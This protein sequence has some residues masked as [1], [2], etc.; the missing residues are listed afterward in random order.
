MCVA[1]PDRKW[2]GGRRSQPR[3]LENLENAPIFGER[4]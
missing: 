3:F 2:L 4:V 1:D